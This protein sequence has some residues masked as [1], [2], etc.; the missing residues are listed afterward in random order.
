MHRRVLAAVFA[1]TLVL[2]GAAAAQFSPLQDD[3]RRDHG[4]RVNPFVGVLTGFTR[5]ER[6]LYDDGASAGFAQADVRL[7]NAPIVGL[8]IETPLYRNLGVT[9]A[10]GYASRGETYFTVRQSD[11]R[12]VTDGAHV[13]AGRLGVALQLQEL[14]TEMVL[15]RTTASVHVAGAVMHEVTR[16]ALGVPDAST[17]GTHFG[18]N[19]GATAEVPFAGDRLAVQVGVEDN[20]MWWRDAPLTNLAWVYFNRP[21]GTPATT[22]AS[23]TTSHMF[24]LRAGLRFRL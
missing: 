13:I 21:G 6:W 14:V 17:D 3:A 16:N 2:P 8:H 10:A 23:A 4:F 11:E 15:R 7:A 19:F 22:A 5:A 12:L 24:L 18:V 1:A 9:A 20:M